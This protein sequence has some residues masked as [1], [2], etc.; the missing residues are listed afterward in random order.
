MTIDTF[1]RYVYDLARKDGKGNVVS[2]GAIVNWLT[3]VMLDNFNDLMTQ[4]LT[5]AEQRQTG[6][7]NVIFDIKDL[8]QF[9]KTIELSTPTT[10]TYGTLTTNR[11]ALP[12]D[13]KYELGGTVNYNTPTPIASLELLSST[14][15]PK[16]R[17]SV[18]NGNPEESPKG[19]IGGGYIE[20]IPNDINE[21]V[22]VYLRTPAKPYYD[23]CL[24]SLDNEIFMPVGS[25]IRLNQPL[26]RYDLSSA[27]GDVLATNVVKSGATYPYASLT[28][29][30]DWDETNH[31]R[32]ANVV[33]HKLGINLKNP[34]LTQTQ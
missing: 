20:T 28:V 29:E 10:G 30:L 4:A 12:S 17:G 14:L 1:I 19:F 11:F 33:A 2:P 23:F 25:T 27:T 5:L 9:V 34:I 32:F 13:F 18:V 7:A 3:F 6:L 15:L 16:Y 31:V 26:S 21:V 8:R 24:D 22:L